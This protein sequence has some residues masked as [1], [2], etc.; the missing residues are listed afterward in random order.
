MHA[1]K[2]EKKRFLPGDQ[3]LEKEEEKKKGLPKMVS[4]GL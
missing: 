1:Q 3:P 2:K 4:L